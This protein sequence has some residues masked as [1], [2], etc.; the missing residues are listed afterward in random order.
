MANAAYGYQGFFGAKYYC[1]EAAAST[2][3]FARENIM[4]A[5]KVF[6]K[7]NFNII[8]SDTDSIAISL[9][10][11]SEKQALEVLNKINKKLPGIMELEYEGLFKRGIWVAKRTGEFGAKKK[12]ALIDKNNKIKIR[13]F[14]TVRRDWCKLARDVQSHILQLILKQGNEKQSLEYIKKIIKQIQNREIPLNQLII[15]TQLKKPIEEYKSIPPHVTIAKKMQQQELP[16]NI[17]M[18]I[19]YYIAEPENHQK[20][21]TGKNKALVRERAKMIDEPGKYDIEYYL[22]NQIIP[23]VE[24]IFEVFKI[25]LRELAEGKNQKKLFEF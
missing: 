24:N 4:S 2:A 22:N 17:G 1:R 6:K 3:Y 15:K 10:N 23:A 25:N 8:Y 20:T 12:Y 18:L 16:V 7:N 21:K 19:E 14:E 11:K 13:G 9:G 5:I